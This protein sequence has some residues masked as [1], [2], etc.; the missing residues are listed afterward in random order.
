MSNSMR[1]GGRED[2]VLVAHDRR[3][4]EV[5]HREGDSRS[6]EVAH[7]R[8]GATLRSIDGTLSVAEV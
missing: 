2:I 4:I 7:D 3:R 6:L 8:G 1:T 5:W